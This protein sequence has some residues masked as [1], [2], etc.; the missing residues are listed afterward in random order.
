MEV[1]G[2]EVCTFV[3]VGSLSVSESLS[4]RIGFV[5]D[6]FA[7]FFFEDEVAIVVGDVF[8]LMTIRG[9]TRYFSIS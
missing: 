8:L 6:F 7:F 5:F 4:R 1:G 2:S 9:A 3:M